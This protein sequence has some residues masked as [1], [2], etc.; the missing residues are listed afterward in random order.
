MDF[1]TIIAIFLCVRKQAL[2]QAHEHIIALEIPILLTDGRNQ[3]LEIS[4]DLSE[5]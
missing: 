1:N 3:E 4:V 2:L 5:V